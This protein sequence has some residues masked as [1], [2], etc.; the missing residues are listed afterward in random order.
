MPQPLTS[1]Q[2]GSPGKPLAGGSVSAC[3]GLRRG[4]SLGV[5]ADASGGP[6]GGVG[7]TLLLRNPLGSLAGDLRFPGLRLL[8]CV[9]GDE[10]A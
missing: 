6:L 10:G 7:E 3:L 1:G 5:V 8:M 2:A 9:L 4:L